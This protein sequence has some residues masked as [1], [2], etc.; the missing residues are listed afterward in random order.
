LVVEAAARFRRKHRAELRIP[1]QMRR[2]VVAAE[3]VAEA[4]ELAVVVDTVRLAVLEV[5]LLLVAVVVGKVFFGPASL[6][7]QPEATALREAMP[8]VELAGLVRLAHRPVL[9]PLASGHLAGL[10]RQLTQP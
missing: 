6:Q 5:A 3:A 4:V 10:V 8:E 9:R 7:T 1:F 2:L